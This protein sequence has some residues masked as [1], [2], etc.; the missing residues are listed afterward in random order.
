MAPE[1]VEQTAVDAEYSHVIATVCQY[2]E[3]AFHQ[4]RP[5]YECNVRV[6][7]VCSGGGARL[8]SL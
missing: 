5:S 6:G 2:C 1:L 8:L 4:F 3:V 7:D